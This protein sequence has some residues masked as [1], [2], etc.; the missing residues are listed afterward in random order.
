MLNYRVIMKNLKK[1]FLEMVFLPLLTLLFTI[2]IIYLITSCAIPIIF[3]MNQHF[4]LVVPVQL[5]QLFPKGVFP[6]QKEIFRMK[7]IIELFLHI[8]VQVNFGVILIIKNDKI[9]LQ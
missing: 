6:F 1:D 9:L 8:V 4:L 7:I 5:N 2:L 3:F